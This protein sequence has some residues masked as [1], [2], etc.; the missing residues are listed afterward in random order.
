MRFI[1]ISR[2]ISARIQGNH[3]NGQTQSKRLLWTVENWNSV[4]WH[5]F[6]SEDNEGISDF[7]L[8]LTAAICDYKDNKLFHRS[9]E[10]K[11]QFEDRHETDEWRTATDPS[12][13]IQ[14]DGQSYFSSGCQQRESA[15]LPP[16][17]A[18]GTQTPRA[19]A[20]SLWL[21]GRG[22]GRPMR[23]GYGSVCGFWG[24][25]I[26]N[27]YENGIGTSCWSESD[28]WTYE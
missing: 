17:E 21:F 16:A 22:R 14:K 28:S 9:E 1:S 2:N 18:G 20:S 25:G 7:R 6:T 12:V 23:N 5:E 15:S 3:S 4:Y 10:L 8:R 13:K 26:K 27:D 11:R 24:C 19:P